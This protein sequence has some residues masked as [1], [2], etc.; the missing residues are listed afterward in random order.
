[1]AKHEPSPM[2]DLK[3]QPNK[4]SRLKIIATI[5]T[6]A[7][8][9]LFIYF[10]YKVGL[11][12]IWEGFGRVGFGGF[13]IAFLLYA[14]RLGIRSFTWSFSVE[15]PYGLKFRDAYTAVVMGEAMSS[16]IP[17]GIIVSGTTKGLAVRKKLPL[18]AG[19]SALAIENLFYSLVTGIYISLGAVALLW[20]FN[21]PDF[22]YWVSG[23]LIVIVGLL[24]IAGFIMV[25]QQWH[26]ASATAQWVYEKGIFRSWLETAR[27]DISNFENRIYGFYR[28]QPKRFLPIFVLQVLFHLLGILEVWLILSF[29]GE[30]APTLFSAF[31]LE[32]ISRVI[33]VIFKLVPFVLGVDEAGAQFI[34]NIL[35][36]GAGIGV[37]LAIVRKGVRVTWAII[38]VLMLLNR[39]FSIK[40]LF[41]HHSKTMENAH[42]KDEKL[43]HQTN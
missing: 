30:V 12:E 5:L 3:P 10:I 38:G 18:F 23:A 15:K 22:W 17:L 6:L 37:T 24:I 40:E 19:L 39:G 1:M 42:D 43:S 31:L 2:K 7:G 29:L 4:F 21:L 36:L 34:T 16:I 13:L 32:S 14:T 33:V 35:K 11:T 27:A 28:H 26:F 41:H 20:N 9:A 8:L 25:I